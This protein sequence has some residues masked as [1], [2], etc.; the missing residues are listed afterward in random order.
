MA[1]AALAATT[2]IAACGSNSPTS[3]SASGS[4]GQSSQARLQ[5]AQQAAVRFAGCLRSHGVH[6]FP[7]PTSPEDLKS[8]FAGIQSPAIQSAATACRHLL[9]R[10]GSPSQTAAQRR[11]QTVAALA[12]ARCLRSHGFPQFPDPSSTGELTHQMLAAAGIDIHQPAVVHAADA[13]V[14]VTHGLITRAA[15]ARFVT[16]Q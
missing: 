9:G 3:S 15:V 5:Q 6:N 11:A 10:G 8:S 12:F 1:A 4:A 13:C 2:V 7:D 14:D 16:G